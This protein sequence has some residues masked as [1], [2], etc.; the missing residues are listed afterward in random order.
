MYDLG[1]G[2]FGTVRA[3][4]TFVVRD[5]KIVSDGLVFDTYELRRFEEAQA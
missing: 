5:G 2:P 3:A 4:D 1:T